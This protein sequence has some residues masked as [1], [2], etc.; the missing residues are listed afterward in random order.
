MIQDPSPDSGARLRFKEGLQQ[1]FPDNL[2]S[3]A[4][5]VINR[6]N[7]H[8]VVIIFKKAENGLDDLGECFIRQ[9]L[10]QHRF[11]FRPARISRREA[12]QDIY[13]SNMKLI[14]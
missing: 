2:I 11:R 3:V 7:A 8:I 14:L 4:G 12:R 5:K 1:P 10:D 13:Q 9:M 6:R